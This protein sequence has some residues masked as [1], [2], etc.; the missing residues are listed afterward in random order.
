MTQNILATVKIDGFYLQDSQN[1]W[2]GT[3]E[4]SKHKRQWVTWFIRSTCLVTDIG[5]GLW[6][7]ILVCHC[8]ASFSMK[9]TIRLEDA[10]SSK[11]S[12]SKKRHLSFLEIEMP[13]TQRQVISYHPVVPPC[14]SALPTWRGLHSTQEEMFKKA[15]DET[16]GIR[17]RYNGKSP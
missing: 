13:S 9:G 3:A 15:S 14:L 8:S 5:C 2:Q 1:T 17:N 11:K 16:R 12:H 7:T 4:G 6:E 10:S